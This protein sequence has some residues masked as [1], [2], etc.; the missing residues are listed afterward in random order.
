MWLLLSL[1][2]GS[3]Y[4]AS[5]LIS[6]YV[7]KKK[8]DPWAFSFYFSTVGAFVSL[9]FIFFDESNKLAML[10]L[11]ILFSLGFLIVLHN[12]LK[13]KSLNFASVSLSNTVYKFRLVAIFAF[14]IFTGQDVFSY[15]KLLGVL[16]VTVSGLFLLHSFKKEKSYFGLLLSLGAAL[17]YAVVISAMK[18]LFNYFSVSLLTFMIFAVPAMLN[19]LI[20]PK[21]KER[22]VKLYKQEGKMV[23]IACFFG[24]LANLSINAAYNLSTVSAVAV[25]L[26][27]FLIL[28]L[29]LETLVLN[30]K[31]QLIAKVLAVIVALMGAIL[32]QLG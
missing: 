29:L 31:E 18:V 10:P 28:V 32:V 22:I 25:I 26:E 17:V 15:N 9:P 1:A 7:L 24:A 19:Y 12:Y 5:D 8:L 16:L 20:M 13:M 6:R 14:A 30:E 27:V 23:I 21:A 2:A 11:L 3:F 4:T